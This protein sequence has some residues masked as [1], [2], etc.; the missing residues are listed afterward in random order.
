MDVSV[1]RSHAMGCPSIANA[2]EGIRNLLP[3][4]PRKQ[5][6]S[7]SN[8]WGESPNPASRSRDG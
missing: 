2:G 5:P 3:W 7:A 1:D 6:V 8:F 4:Q